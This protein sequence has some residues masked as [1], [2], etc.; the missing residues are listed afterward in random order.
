[1]TLRDLTKRQAYNLRRKLQ[2]R[3]KAFF[4]SYLE[5]TPANCFKVG[6]DNGVKDLLSMLTKI[7]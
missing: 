7:E 4:K 6:Y 5:K 3:E 1:M 2:K